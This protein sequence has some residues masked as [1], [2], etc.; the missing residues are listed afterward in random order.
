[1]KR[2]KENPWSVFVYNHP[3]NSAV[4][5]TVTRLTDFGAFVELEP[6][7]EGLV[8]VSQIAEER[9]ERPEQVLKQGEKVK[10]VI[11][12][13]DEEAGKISLSIKDFLKREE[14]QA[15][16]EFLSGL[17]VNRGGHNLGELL[18]NAAITIDKPSDK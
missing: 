2:L 1:M 5:G 11:Q 7:I 14:K 17:G 15:M 18:R 10:C 6:G 13:V 9:V 8:H 16:K 3:V 4:E 12:R